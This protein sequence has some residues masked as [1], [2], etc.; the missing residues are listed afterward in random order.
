M[1]QKPYQGMIAILD[2]R[3][4][5]NQLIAWKVEEEEFLSKSTNSP[6]I[7]WELPGKVEWTVA[8]GKVVIPE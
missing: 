1:K 5:Y 4:Q 7:G 6:F 8:G 2:F 3:S